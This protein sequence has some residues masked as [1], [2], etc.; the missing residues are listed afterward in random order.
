MLAKPNQIIIQI[1]Q[2]EWLRDVSVQSAY[3]ST[4][5][6]PLNKSRWLII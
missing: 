6:M 3:A 1:Y 5:L 4:I 2:I